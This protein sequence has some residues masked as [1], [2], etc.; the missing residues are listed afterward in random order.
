MSL[1]NPNANFQVSIPALYESLTWNQRR[2]VREQYIKLQKYECFFCG[3]SL[4]KEAPEE[5]QSLPID[6]DLFPPEFTKYPVHLQHNH[7]TGLTEGAVH[8][9]CNA[10]MW[11]YFRR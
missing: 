7:D 1:S 5:L 4:Y 3:G 10:F 8:S 2:V 11:N 6:W 9:F